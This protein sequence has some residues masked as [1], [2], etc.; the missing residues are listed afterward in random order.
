MLDFDGPFWLIAYN[1]AIYASIITAVV[2][3]SIGFA[4]I[5]I[6]LGFLLV[7]YVA[8]IIVRFRL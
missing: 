8:L 7:F 1:A 3:Q 2:M 4:I 5:S 6:V